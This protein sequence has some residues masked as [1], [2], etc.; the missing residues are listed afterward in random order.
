[1]LFVGD[2]FL[3]SHTLCGS[4]ASE[5]G[6]EDCTMK[7]RGTHPS[8]ST[9]RRECLDRTLILGRRHVEQVLAKYIAFYN[10]H[11]PHRAIGQQSPLA[12]EPP[13]IR[14]PRSAIRDPK[15]TELRCHD[16]VLG[17]IHEY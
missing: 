17:L 1:M 4:D 8:M 14:D 15:P 11:L 3:V 12:V 16:A 5:R 13:P 7:R 2:R 10:G 6:E 9:F